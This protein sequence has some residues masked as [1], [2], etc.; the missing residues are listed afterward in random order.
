MCIRDRIFTE[1]HFDQSTVPINRFNTDHF[2]CRGRVGDRALKFDLSVRGW[3]NIQN[4]VGRA[5]IQFDC[6]Y[7]RALSRGRRYEARGKEKPEHNTK[8]QTLSH[9][10]HQTSVY[11]STHECDGFL[12]K[13]NASL[14]ILCSARRVHPQGHDGLS[15]DI[16]RPIQPLKVD[17]FFLAQF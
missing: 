4:R 11:A 9:G 13:K 12:S 6:R 14:L 15:K 1:C 2:T 10:C 8:N 7:W 5:A 3:T 17:L 16:L